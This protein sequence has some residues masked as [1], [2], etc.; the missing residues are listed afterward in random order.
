MSMSS[1]SLQA[2][3]RLAGLC[4][5]ATIV[6]GAFDHLFVA[7]LLVAPGDAAATTQR[8][9]TSEGLYRLAFAAEMI[10]VY[11]VVT[12]LL[13]DLFSPV[14]RSLALLAA[15]CSL[16]GGAV[17][18]GIG[19]LQLA[20]V[21]VLR[22]PFAAGLA[23]DQLHALVGVCLRLQQVGFSISLVFFGFYCALLGWLILMST[24]LPR[25][26]GALV[27]TGG[28]AWVTYALADLAAPDVGAALGPAALLLGTA[29][30]GALTAWLL[31]CG[32]RTPR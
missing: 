6:V 15:F 7:G 9:A 5:L 19:V 8:L 12:V 29:G 4:Y 11:V 10:P 17:G 2:K 22:D 23:N 25:A 1:L 14:D 27:A 30:E 18:S 20:P 24:L 21:V 13:Y 16:V 26:V 32:V 31:V 3:A 28:V